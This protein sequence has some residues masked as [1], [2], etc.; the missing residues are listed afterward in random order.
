M[1]MKKKK[2]ST[3]TCDSTNQ[4]GTIEDR[5]KIFR[6]YNPDLYKKYELFFESN[7]DK[8]IICNGIELILRTLET[9]K[10]MYHINYDY[11]ELLQINNK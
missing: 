8:D 3:N 5:I 2:Y 1:M 4:G 10:I 9:D 11:Y 7:D 6:E